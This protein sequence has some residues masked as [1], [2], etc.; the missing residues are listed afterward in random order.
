MVKLNGIGASPGT[1]IGKLY[2]YRHNVND[3]PRYEASVPTAEWTRFKNAQAKAIENLGILAE[4]ARQDAGEEAALLFETHQLM[5]DDPDF[6]EDIHA[7][8]FENKLNAEAAVQDA[9][10]RFEEMFKAMDDPYFQARAADVKDIG[11]R[12]IEAFDNTGSA[13]FDPPEPAILAADDLS[14]SETMQI[15]KSKCLGFVTTGGSVTSHTSI[16]A[17]NMGLPAIIGLGGQLDEKYDGSLVIIDGDTGKFIASPDK[18]T[19]AYYLSKIYEL[20]KERIELEKFKGLS[21]ITTDG[22]SIKICCNI[23]SPDDISAVLEN[24]ADGIGLFRSEFLYIGRDDLPDE[25]TQFES[26]GQVLAAMSGRHVVIRTLDIGADKQADYLELP[27][28]ENPALGNRALRLCLDRPEIFRTQ[29]RALYRA[30]VYGKLGIMFPM[31]TSVWEVKE[32]KRICESVKRELAEEGIPYDK[33]MEIGIMIETPAA[34]MISDLLAEEVDFF[35]IGTNDLTQY[36]L[37]CDRQNKNLDRYY[38]PHHP[39]I[40]RAI[41]LVC[42]NARSH[43]VRT[44]ICGELAADRSMTG[45]LLAIGIDELSVSPKQ[46]LPLRQ[47]IRSI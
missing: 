20:K 18:E 36:M 5:A 28:E 14:P 10:Y 30:S 35:S 21:N 1:A 44:A 41:Q 47:K 42:E 32:A 33:N 22:R 13:G 8:I 25:E 24:D 9:A 46:V 6:T 7:S 40:I 12:I 16:L 29:L 23:S 3:I 45:I 31:I 37:A 2:W 15:N 43:G 4:K 19:K 17:R 11:K 34:V 38:D 39:S 26:Y 27:K